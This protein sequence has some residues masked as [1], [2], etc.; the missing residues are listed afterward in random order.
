MQL[1][2]V[3]CPETRLFSA[4]DSIELDTWV[5]S[6]LKKGCRHILINFQNVLFIDS[7]GIGALM[8]ALKKV[9][10]AK[11]T[12]GLCSVCEQA[13]LVINMAGIGAVLKVFESPQEFYDYLSKLSK[14]SQMRCRP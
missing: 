11:G 5:D 6:Q 13:K 7:Q 14:L 8:K 12:F 10:Q 2:N 3:Y 9:R 4:A 1:V